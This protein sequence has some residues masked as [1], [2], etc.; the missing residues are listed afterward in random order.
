MT[1]ENDSPQAGTAQPDSIPALPTSHAIKKAASKA[2][3]PSRTSAPAELMTAKPIPKRTSVSDITPPR[4]AGA[5]AS[6]PFHEDDMH[7]EP[8]ANIRGPRWDEHD[9][10]DREQQQDKNPKQNQ[11]P[12]ANSGRGSTAFQY[13]DLSNSKRVVDQDLR[14]PKNSGGA[15]PGVVDQNEDINH[16]NPAPPA[17]SKVAPP[18]IVH[19]MDNPALQQQVQKNPK[20][21]ALIAQH[22][23][24][25][26]WRLPPPKSVPGSKEGS[27]QQQ[28]TDNAESLVRVPK[29]EIVPAKASSIKAAAPPP[30][31]VDQNQAVQNPPA[32]ELL[33]THR[34]TTPAAQRIARDLPPASQTFT[35]PPEELIPL[36]VQTTYAV[37]TGEA[38]IMNPDGSIGTF[39]IPST[40]SMNLPRGD[41]QMETNHPNQD[42][43]HHRRRTPRSRT[44]DRRQHNDR[45][46][47]RETT[48]NNYRAARNN[49]RSRGRG[50]RREQQSHHGDH[51][52]R[53]ENYD[54]HR[55]APARS[56]R[57]HESQSVQGTTTRKNHTSRGRDNNYRGN[58]HVDQE[59]E[60]RREREE[61]LQRQEQAERDEQNAL[62]AAQQE[63]RLKKLREQEELAKKAQ[64]EAEQ[65]ARQ[66]EELRIQQERD[67][68]ARERE[69]QRVREQKEERERAE[70][71]RAERERAE[72]ERAERERVER[73][74][75]EREL[76]QM[77]MRRA[78][79][80]RDRAEELQRAR[81]EWAEQEQA[82]VEREERRVRREREERER[83]ETREK[84][85]EEEEELRRRRDRESR[86]YNKNYAVNKNN[87][88]RASSRDRDIVQ[89]N[90]K[91][92]DFSSSREQR[93]HTTKMNTA[94]NSRNMTDSRGRGQQHPSRDHSRGRT[95][96]NANNNLRGAVDARSTKTQPPAASGPRGTSSRR[97]G[98]RE[99]GAGSYRQHREERRND[100]IPEPDEVL[101]D[102]IQD[103]NSSAATMRGGRDKNYERHHDHDG[104]ERSG[105][106]HQNKRRRVSSSG[107]G[108]VP[109]TYSS[110]MEQK[111][112]APEQPS[113]RMNYEQQ[114]KQKDNQHEDE[115]YKIVAPQL[116]PH[117]LE[118]LNTVIANRGVNRAK[119]P[120]DAAAGVGTTNSTQLLPSSTTS[121]DQDAIGNEDVANFFA[122]KEE[123][124]II[125][126]NGMAVKGIIDETFIATNTVGL[127]FTKLMALK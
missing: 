121:G 79:E 72:R 74:R 63:A 114:N 22:C 71:E 100:I 47:A 91:K 18:A 73:E 5:P 20:L 84:Q 50:G 49:S 34:T 98:G 30:V 82:R 103:N 23:R 113:S 90:E 16:S 39:S 108:A 106:Q 41:E 94:Q 4:A 119:N 58:R 13:P 11:T 93:R 101:S 120:A 102:Q 123:V 26:G 88:T 89:N 99:P 116:P 124:T 44:D 57:D 66:R 97:R 125:K 111:Q 127:F 122:S 59:A 65:E 83:A 76:E 62:W 45:G 85:R 51:A 60:Q 55:A 105:A 19:P 10:V 21:A 54:R 2:G 43:N 117:L 25:T 67:R 87:H 37:R 29:G 7:Q 61:R 1:E 28:Q 115:I 53:R 33:P 15:A 24:S 68:A 12:A 36:E 109:T 56:T 69:A 27:E 3:P 64:R 110:Y 96:N 118:T 8:E 95:G 9:Q 31:V 112:M 32:E 104:F 86:D 81:Q 126:A 14:P 17:V 107:G 42:E 40:V 48:S 35:C 80:E 52:D 38:L 77:R 70:R 92:K 46:S 6:N 78:Q 75:V